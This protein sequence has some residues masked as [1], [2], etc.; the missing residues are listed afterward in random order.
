MGEQASFAR[1]INQ[2][3]HLLIYPSK[4]SQLALAQQL[5]TTIDDEGSEIILPLQNNSLQQ[6]VHAAL[7]I[8]NN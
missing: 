2:Q 6:V 7:H 1:P 8:R 4:K 3:A 5:A